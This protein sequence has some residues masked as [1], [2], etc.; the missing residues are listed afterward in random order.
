MLMG[1]TKVL[2]PF[3][4]LVWLGLVWFL[5]LGCLSGFGC[6]VADGEVLAGKLLVA[7]KCF[8]FVSGVTQRVSDFLNGLC[9]PCGGG[10][11]VFGVRKG[12]PVAEPVVGEF[13]P[14][15]DRRSCGS[16]GEQGAGS[17]GGGCAEIFEHWRCVDVQGDSVGN[18]EP[19]G[20]EATQLD[21]VATFRFFAVSVCCEVN[22]CFGR[23][24]LDGLVREWR[25]FGGGRGIGVGETEQDVGEIS[26]IEFGI[27]LGWDD[28]LLNGVSVVLQVNAVAAGEGGVFAKPAVKGGG[29]FC[30]RLFGEWWLVQILSEVDRVGFWTDVDF[31]IAVVPGQIA[32]EGSKATAEVGDGARQDGFELVLVGGDHRVDGAVFCCAVESGIRLR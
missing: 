25:C 24:G 1:V 19:G 10:H 5:C 21:G 22:I 28:R 17:I 29:N 23:P 31:S 26:W 12:C 20:L 15:K 32:A 14:N 4:F 13:G 11:R 8:E 16:Q 18:F 2:F 30:K 6:D 7:V 3:V 9:Q 27:D